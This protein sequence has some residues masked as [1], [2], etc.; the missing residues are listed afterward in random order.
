MQIQSF[1]LA[2]LAIGDFLMG[3][4]LIIIASVDVYYRGDYARHDAS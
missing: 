3:I 2:N 1:M 4:Y